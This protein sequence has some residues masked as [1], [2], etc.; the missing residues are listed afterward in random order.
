MTELSKSHPV[1]L[2]MKRF[3]ACVL[4]MAFGLRASVPM[5]SGPAFEERHAWKL[6]ALDWESRLSPGNGLE[7]R[8]GLARSLRRLGSFQRSA[9]EWGIVLDERPSGASASEA[10]L[11]LAESLQA[12]GDYESSQQVL[13][14]RFPSAMPAEARLIYAEN[15][16]G[17]GHYQEAE[18]AYRGL[19]EGYPGFSKPEYLPYARAWSLFKLAESPSRGGSEETRQESYAKAAELFAQVT[20]SW[21]HSDLGP[22]ALYQRAECFYALKKYE[23]ASQAY[24]QLE[25]DY[26]GH[27]LVAPARYAM[28][29]CSFDLA[30]WQDAAQ[31]FHRFAVVH[32]SHELAPWAMYMA[33]VSLARAKDYDLAQSAYELTLKKYPGSPCEDKARYGLAWLATVRKDYDA[34]ALA[35]EAFLEKFADSPLAASALFLKADALYHQERYAAARDDYLKLLKRWPGHALSEDALFYAAGSSL[36]E[37]EYAQA[38][39]EYQQFL[40]LSPESHYGPEAKLRLADAY[41]G[42]GDWKKAEEAYGVLASGGSVS[43]EPQARSGLAWISFGQKHWEEAGREW[44][45]LAARFPDHPLAAESLLHAGDAAYNLGRYEEA[46]GLYRQAAQKEHGGAEEAQAH[47]QAGWACYRL[48]NFE[49]AYGEWGNARALG[50]SEAFASEA[51]YWMAWSLFRKGDYAGAARDFAALREAYPQSYLFLEA[52]LR[53]ADSLYNAGIYQEA[54]NLYQEL[55]AKAPNDERAAAALHGI[56][57]CYYA[58]GKD[59]EAIAAS[60]AFLEKHKDAAVAPEV[61]YRVAEHYVN[62]GDF[63]QAEKELDTLKQDYPKSKVDFAAS[64]WRG[65][66]RFKNLKFNEAIQDWK[67]LMEKAPGHPLAPKAAFKIGMAYYRLQEYPQALESFGQVLESYGNTPE[68]AADAMFNR[69]MTY[70]RMHEDAQAIKSYEALVGAYPDGPLASMARIRIGYIYE[71]SR[72]FEHAIAAYRDLAAHDTGK[73]GAEAQYLVGDCYFSQKKEGEAL[74]AYKEVAEHFSGQD[75]W[76]VTALAKVGELEEGLGH[77]DKALEAYEKIRAMGGDPTWVASAKKRI[78]LLKARMPSEKKKSHKG[79][80]P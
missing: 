71:D 11:G 20:E 8:P 45:D 17:L 2:S 43:Q 51:M 34:A 5:E 40:R 39:G 57:W 56:Q 13:K 44:K 38:A 61:Q 80:E 24:R 54:L 26:R 3:F 52:L 22:W 19:L 23:D 70:K 33:G 79:E 4:L 75:A 69:G 50:K 35:Y 63:K 77:D 16:F 60:K 59:E 42:A 21:P 78:E 46:L 53:Q 27:E 15:L 66:A 48:K 68:V 47:F 36:A 55:V 1:K 10:S 67:E 14:S 6:A 37:G 29:W 73:L 65:Q 76:V 58:L 31:D 28:A 64:Y 62:K 72:D 30:K 74:L 41:Y 7:A 49:Q 18:E 32:E 12:Q 9:R 25:K